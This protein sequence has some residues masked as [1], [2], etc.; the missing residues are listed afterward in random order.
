METR[1]SLK[2]N[3]LSRILLMMRM[4][5]VRLGDGEESCILDEM[6][7]RRRS[8]KSQPIRSRGVVYEESTS[9]T[10]LPSLRMGGHKAV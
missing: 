2:I 1:I 7:S 5:K 6:F 10:R 9:L 8:L 4:R 3:H